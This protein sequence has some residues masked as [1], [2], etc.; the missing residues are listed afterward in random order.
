VQDKACLS[1][2]VCLAHLCKVYYQPP[3]KMFNVDM[4]NGALLGIK[5][6][7][8]ML[9]SRINTGL[10]QAVEGKQQYA[11]CQQQRRNRPSKT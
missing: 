7:W 11:Y 2:A 6:L 5:E 1:K 4:C 10:R 8:C 3:I 9:Y